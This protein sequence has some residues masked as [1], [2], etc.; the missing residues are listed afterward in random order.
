[1][2]KSTFGRPGVETS[3]LEQDQ[4][5]NQTLQNA[6]FNS[7][8]FICMTT[9]IKGVIQRFNIGAQQML[10]YSVDEVMNKLTPAEIA[11]S[12]ELVVR[13]TM[14]S[15]EFGDM[16]E[17]GFNALVFKASRSLED[18][19]PLTFICKNGSRFTAM[20]SV[21]TLRD[22]QDNIIGYLL[23]GT[24][25]TTRKTT[26]TAPIVAEAI[27]EDTLLKADALQSAIFNSANF[28]SI[29]TDANGVIQIFNVGAE[30][31]LGYAA[32]DVINKWTPADISD[33]QE[34]VARAK[35]LSD[36]LGTSIQPG[37]EA[38]VFKASRG[39]EDIYELTYIRKDGCRF[40]AI[41]SV[42]ALRDAQ[43]T[44][45]GYLLIGTDNSARQEA[46]DKLWQASQYA[47]SLLEASL[48]PLVTIN[49]YGKITDVNEASIKATG[50]PR[51]KL[52][53]T[54]FSDY[55]TDPEEARKG[56]REAFSKGSVTDYPLTMRHRNGRL[57]DV[58][59]NASVYRD[60]KGEVLG[61]FAA[62]RDITLRKRADEALL[63]ANALQNAIF[64]SANFSSIATDAKGVI[65]IFNVGAERMLGYTAVDMVDKLTPADISDP[66]EIV[67][68][69]KVLTKEL[70]T[71]ITPGFEA[72]VFK[73][74]RGIEDIY[75][76]T[77]IRKDGSRFPAVVSVTA[78]RD[79]QNN[80]IGYLLIGTDNTARK[81]AEEALLK[82]GA[83]Q[84][85][86]FN[87]ANFSSIA[88][89][90]KG[91]IQIFNVG[92]ERM[93]GY[94][95]AEVMDKITPADISDPQEIIVRAAELSKELDTPI[96]PGFE[97]LVFKA[98]RGIE[99]I[100]ELT[101]IRKDG[102]RF[103]AVVSVT[104]L[105][106]AQ[107]NIIGYL[108][109][110]T[111]NTARKRAEEALLKAGALQ[112]AIFNS[113]NFSSIAT[114][115]KGVIQIFNVGAE[116]ML[117]YT[118]AE[119]MDKITPAD[120]S[121]P[122]EIIVRAAELSKELETAI[123]PGFEA[124][125]FK[126]SRGI[127]DIYQLTYIRKDGSRFPAV[128]SVTA[129]RDAKNTIIG[130]L[131]IGTD[132]TARIQVEEERELLTARL[133]DKNAELESSREIA[134]K[135]NRAKSEFL[136][137]MSHELRT[138]LNA[139]L[140][141]AQLLEKGKPSPT[142]AQSLRLHQIIK[143]GWYL[144]ALINEILDLAVIESGRLSLSR[145]S[146][147]LIDVIHESRAMVE[148]QAF[149]RDIQLDFL[150]FDNHWH[151]SADHTR[152]KQVLINLLT[153]AIKYN[154]QHG[155]I[156]V[157][158]SE[159]KDSESSNERLRINITDTGNGLSPEKLTQ[160]FQPFNRLGQEDGGEEGTGIGLVVT[161]QLV[162]LMGGAI[163]VKS[164][165][166]VGSEFWIELN[167]DVPP[168]L[169]DNKALST[170]LIPQVSG[171]DDICSLLYVEDNPANLMLVQQIIDDQPNMRMLSASDGHKGIALART[172]LPDVILM[173]INLPGISG[174]E[175]LA[176][177]KSDPRTAHI[178]VLA[179]S[180]NA[181]P[182][183]IKKG[184]K[185]GFLR[186]LTK[187]IKISEFIEA[188]DFALKNAELSGEI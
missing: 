118:A 117:G 119:V 147:L 93:L 170:D 27:A 150:P 15:A 157:Q 72:L 49:I 78:L 88:T 140:G 57:M 83:L 131:L 155:T 34:V 158:C 89:D 36:E 144:L 187:P 146:V 166:G 175:A 45:I 138:P 12:E 104:A 159:V 100:Y 99:D 42:T 52:I 184:L 109:I 105:R 94:T 149:K 108:L 14:L 130:Y 62:A 98:T 151:A 92:A 16:V 165:V 185:A 73:A 81:R 116:R 135:A 71:P 6:I 182:R 127:E 178:P 24:D 156:T 85:A 56:Y 174:I 47:R 18:N 60:D 46:D 121:D 162:E 160:L 17:P 128:V 123:A 143:A 8:N 163:G 30:R 48:D 84:S 19:S 32:I 54:D 167:R 61:L 136:S 82:A 133:Q 55:F 41:V 3:T 1:M 169:V 179:I 148:P 23:I 9:D 111:D 58:L 37:F 120:I 154:R 107:N 10:G 35:A 164:T 129:L 110:G 64:N 181:M 153:N 95:A 2:L 39:I 161:K 113:A 186:Y 122:Q 172:Q 26:E 65:Q 86:I 77:Y 101:Y 145:E 38:L 115:A 112:S 50:I 139:I 40:P 66:Q 80:I 114:D 176:I 171:K 173:D 53:G 21:T 76:L 180:A 5:T 67:I 152:L 90:A 177:L 97:A 29:A 69:A 51:D 91:V 63:K 132:N 168:T 125:V 11:D 68:R 142:D 43:E 96:T 7:D 59:Y 28:S 141:F 44:I 126:A 20:V 87:S 70:D 134:E 106:D 31:M 4:V 188:L 25:N 103:P 137:S 33:P 124:L 74:S 75:E 79:A 22:T 183:D 13:A 102:S